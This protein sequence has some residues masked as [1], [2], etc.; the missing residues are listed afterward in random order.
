MLRQGHRLA[1]LGQGVHGRPRPL[2]D[3]DRPE[4]LARCPVGRHV[5][6]SRERVVDVGADGARGGAQ[7]AKAR[8]GSPALRGVRRAA[9]AALLQR[10]VREHARNRAGSAGG[11]RGGRIR[12]HRPGARPE[13]VHL[14][15]QPQLGQ[16]E[17]AR[18]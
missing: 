13:R 4:L 2:R 9:R 8:D 17:I 1:P 18:Q 11:D 6:A 12:D 16:A 10:R 5:A 14:D 3:R 15:E 7:A